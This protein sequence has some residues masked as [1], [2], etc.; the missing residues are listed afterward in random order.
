VAPQGIDVNACKYH[1]LSNMTPEQIA[2]AQ[3]LT[4][5]F[6]PR[7]VAPGSNSNSSSPTIAVSPIAT[8]TV[9]HHG[10]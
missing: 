2:E 10:R 1:L 9:F 6:V 8:G 3:R 4:H 5:E 7:K